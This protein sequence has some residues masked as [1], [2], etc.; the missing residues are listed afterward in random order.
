MDD[1]PSLHPADGLSILPIVRKNKLAAPVRK[2]QTQRVNNLLIESNRFGFAS[3]PLDNRYMRPELIPSI[4]IHIC[5][6]KPEQVADAECSISP[7]D[8]QRIVAKLSPLQKIFAQFT[9]LALVPD[10]FGCCHDDFVPLVL[11]AV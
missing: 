10:R 1:P 3:F 9:K 5:P 11:D 4:V 7:H 8:D 2:I 6:A